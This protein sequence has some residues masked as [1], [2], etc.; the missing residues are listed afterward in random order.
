MKSELKRTCVLCGVKDI[1]YGVEWHNWYEGKTAHYHCIKSA[2]NGN[3][4]HTE[5]FEIVS[6]ADRANDTGAFS[7]A[8]IIYIEKAL[9]MYKSIS[10]R[11]ANNMR[12][13]DDPL[14]MIY[15]LTRTLEM[16]VE[17]HEQLAGHLSDIDKTA[18]IVFDYYT[19]KLREINSD[20]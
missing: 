5:L 4:A 11:M 20:V 2:G 3:H 14:D 17:C 6:F 16:H 19:E 1:P 7:L 9:N 8:E 12:E 10:T 13:G 15:R 18:K